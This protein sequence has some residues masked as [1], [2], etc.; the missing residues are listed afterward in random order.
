MAIHYKS[1]GRPS[2][3]R[4]RTYTLEFPETT[5]HASIPSLV[6]EPK[7]RGVIHRKADPPERWES[8]QAKRAATMNAWVLPLHFSVTCCLLEEILRTD[9]SILQTSDNGTGK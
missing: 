1:C 2:F 4:T 6:G 3:P 9:G 8:A 5:H 7:S